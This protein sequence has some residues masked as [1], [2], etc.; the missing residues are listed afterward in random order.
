MGDLT[1]GVTPSHQGKGVGKRLFTKFMTIV[2]DDMKDIEKVELIARESNIKA[3]NFYEKIGFV[4]EGKLRNKIRGVDGTL[5][6]DII[7]G[8]IRE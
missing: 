4:V 7:M 1:I 5:E 8:W 3:I 6:K 2:M